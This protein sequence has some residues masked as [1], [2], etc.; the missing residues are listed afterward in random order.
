[1]QIKRQIV[2]RDLYNLKAVFDC[3]GLDLAW[4]L[5]APNLKKTTAE[6]REPI[7]DPATAILIRLYTAYPD[8][9]IL[10]EA[11][12]YADIHQKVVKYGGDTYQRIMDERPMTRGRRPEEPSH[13]F[14]AMLFGRRSGAGNDW[15]KNPNKR[16]V[17]TIE[18]LFLLFEKMVDEQ[19]IKGFE[20]FLAIVQ[21]E[22]FYRG[23][24]SLRDLFDQAWKR[25]KPD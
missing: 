10:P 17:P 15:A 9:Y 6:S 24:E 21:E 8:L 22:A 19:G 11:P 7:K 3:R 5:G 18:R 25:E 14:T 4:L 2:A 13:K 23:M 1:M 16:P 12:S 20:R